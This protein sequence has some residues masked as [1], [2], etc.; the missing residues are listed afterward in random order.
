[1]FNVGPKPL[2]PYWALVKGDHRA[3]AALYP[4][5]LGVELRIDLDDQMWR[6]ETHR[7]ESKADDSARTWRGKF[8]AKGWTDD[9]HETTAKR[10][11]PP[12]SK[13]SL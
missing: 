7:E 2:R 9:E 10:L 5:P 12:L 8:L 1:V 6:T 3:S 13:S 11:V 4:H